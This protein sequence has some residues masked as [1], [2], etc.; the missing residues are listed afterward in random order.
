[1]KKLR[2]QANDPTFWIFCAALL[3]LLVMTLME[4]F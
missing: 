1:M 4:V 2:A 3:A